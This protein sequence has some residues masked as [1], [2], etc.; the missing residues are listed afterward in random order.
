MTII[1]HYNNKSQLFCMYTFSFS[2][3]DENFV[4][5]QKQVWSLFA[6]YKQANPEAEWYKVGHDYDIEANIDKYTVSI[7]FSIA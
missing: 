6:Y 5:R 2:L 4:A 3:V 7:S 1:L